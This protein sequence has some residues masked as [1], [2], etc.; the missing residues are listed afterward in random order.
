MAKNHRAGQTP[1]VPCPAEAYAVNEAPRIEGGRGWI[2]GDPFIFVPLVVGPE[3]HL[4]PW[5]KGSMPPTK[6]RQNEGPTTCMHFFNH[7]MPRWH[8]WRGGGLAGDAS[9]GAPDDKGAEPRIGLE[10]RGRGRDAAME[11]AGNSG[12]MD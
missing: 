8:K 12:G 6:R 2:W 1:Q 4:G 9:A 11:D 5:S 10:G 7:H 3:I